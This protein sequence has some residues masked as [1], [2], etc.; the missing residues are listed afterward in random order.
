MKVAS[1]IGD[2]FN[3]MGLAGKKEQRSYA[4]SRH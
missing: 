4:L 3:S 2:R 1:R